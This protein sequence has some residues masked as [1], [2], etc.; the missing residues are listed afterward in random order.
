MS[1]SGKSGVQGDNMTAK[2]L[3]DY[4]IFLTLK[5]FINHSIKK[6][7]AACELRNVKK[8]RLNKI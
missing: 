8:S 7:P 2:V 1:S 5:E 4:L 6:T 3:A